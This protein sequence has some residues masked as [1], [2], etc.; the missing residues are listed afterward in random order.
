MKMVIGIRTKSAFSAVNVLRL[1][2]N[3]LIEDDREGMYGLYDRNNVRV[4]EV[5]IGEV[6]IEE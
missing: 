3:S 5:R 6:R 2:A 1:L 4:G